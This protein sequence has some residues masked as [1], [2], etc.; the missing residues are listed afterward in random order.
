MAT[1]SL[2][3]QREFLPNPRNFY[4]AEGARL[5]R[6]NSKGWCAVYGDICPSHRS[7]S[8]R[9]FSVN[10]STGE[11]HCFSCR[12]GGGDVVDFVRLRDKC[13]FKT[14]A[15]ALGCWRDVSEAERQEFD[16]QAARR[17][18][19]GEFLAEANP[20]TQL[21]PTFGQVEFQSFLCS[22]KQVLISVQLL[23]DSAFNLEDTLS[24]AFAVRIGRRIN[25]SYTTGS[26]TGE[27]QGL[28]TAILAAGSPNIVDA[29]G[30]STN[31]GISG[32]TEANSIGSDDL[33]NLISAVDPMY[34]ANGIFMLNYKT[35]D[36]LRKLKNRY[37][38]PLWSA[39]LAVGEPDR[40][41]GHGFEWNSDLDLIGAGKYP[42]IFG[43]FSRHVIRDVGGITLAR[44]SE[45]FMGSHQVGFQ[46]WLRTDSR[47]L[48]TAAFALLRN[49]L[50]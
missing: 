1:A 23:Q 22:S 6:P 31:D 27:P 36:F 32:N 33:D 48:Q 14:A 45:L 3:F 7:R 46:S 21:N 30:S 13:D 49:P 11:F 50:S 12:G 42:A 39:S 8:K 24:E 37:G 41:Y 10:L 2:A 19:A 20:V 16:R 47:C 4:E 44:F 34:R 17:R 18:A 38:R 15:K 5:G 35:I 40:I 9:S 43:D 28:I 25:T 29:V 26:G